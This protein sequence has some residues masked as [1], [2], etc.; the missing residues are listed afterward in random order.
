MTHRERVEAAL[1]GKSVDRPPISAWRHFFSQENSAED[2]ADAML[3]FQREY[4][5][6]F[7]KVNPRASYHAEDWGVEMRFSDSDAEGPSVEH[8][9]VKRAEDWDAVK[10]LEVTQ[11]VLGEQL[12]AL[13]RIADGLAGQ[14][15]YLMTV[16]TPLSIAERL[17]GSPDAMLRY[18]R[19]D[20]RR[21][22]DALQRI[23]DT[24]IEFGR[25]CLA[26]GAS[27]TFFAT[28]GWATRDAWSEAEYREVARPY[29]LRFLQALDG[30]EFHLLHVCRSNNMLAAFADYPVAA[31]NWD[32]Q[33]QTNPSLAEGAR[34]TGKCVV[35]G[36]SHGT[37][38]GEGTPQDVAAQVREHVGAMTGSRW[39]LG[40]GCTYAPA[41]PE[42]NVRALRAAVDP[43]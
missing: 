2:M 32:S 33:D 12:E 42:A 10:P 28:T 19:H 29:D 21:V 36:V 40:T 13:R 23:T 5:W 15:P 22:Q 1:K 34:L 41:V 26:I 9:P 17:A 16:F 30:A 39:M 11:G 18:L 14:V 8:W 25:E 43:G 35:G 6:D 20:T 3:R 4:K 31:L 37:L 7:M 38:L 27:G 24:F